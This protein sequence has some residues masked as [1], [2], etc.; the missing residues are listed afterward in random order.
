MTS[1]TGARRVIGA[2]LAV[3]AALAVP[4]AAVAAPAEVTLKSGSIDLPGHD[5][6]ICGWGAT[7]TS[8]GQFHF[9][10]VV[11]SGTDPRF[12]QSHVHETVNYTLVI[13]DDPSVPVALRGAT[14]RG[15]FEDTIVV[16]G[17]LLDG[18]FHLTIVS[19]FAE[20]PFHG[21]RD[22]MTLFISAD[23]TIQVERHEIG[24]EADCDA[25]AG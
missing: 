25:L 13:D 22:Q 6:N 1:T 16:S 2:T 21:L 9:G 7:F 4:A 8:T 5:L 3:V 14:W 15:R 24:G 19:T 12:V 23:G 20:G 10:E 18:R 11:V 17:S